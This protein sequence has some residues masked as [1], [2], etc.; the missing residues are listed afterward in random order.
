ME[1]PQ[2]PNRTR[3]RPRRARRPTRAR[4][5]TAAAG[6]PGFGTRRPARRASAG[7]CS[8][9]GAAATRRGAAGRPPMLM[10]AARR[11]VLSLLHS[12]ASSRGRS[13]FSHDDDRRRSTRARIQLNRRRGS[14][15][16]R[17]RPAASRPTLL[18]RRRGASAAAARRGL[19]ASWRRAA[20]WRV[21]RPRAAFLGLCA[22]P[23]FRA[24]PQRAR[25][26]PLARRGGGTAKSSRDKNFAA[27]ARL[28]PH[29]QRARSKALLAQIDLPR[30]P[31]VPAP[32]KRTVDPQTCAPL[33][34][35]IK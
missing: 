18:H 8:R 7:P 24:L 23:G 14:T 17:R 16:K 9:R 4:P 5:W 30:G 31:E 21:R 25:A 10:E 27:L 2:Q 22:A 32:V 35:L 1:A 11:A 28:R 20:A 26:N 34:A 15:H 19:S 33:A 29:S 3:G 6:A 13:S 12:R